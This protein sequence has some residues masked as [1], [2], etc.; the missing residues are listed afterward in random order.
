MSFEDALRFYAAS[1]MR[2][3]GI[4]RGRGHHQDRGGHGGHDHGDPR[5]RRMR[6]FLDDRPPRADRGVVRFLVLD[7]LSE[8]PRH[9]YE[10]MAA[11]ETKSR[12][13]Y[14][15]SPGV[16]YPTLQLLD[17]LG[18]VRVTERDD[19]RVYA[20]TAAGS[21]ELA[22]HADE[23]SRFYEDAEGPWDDRADDLFELAH[24]VKRLLRAFRRSA[25]RGKLTRETMNKATTILDRAIGEL[26][27]LFD[28]RDADEK[29]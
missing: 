23:V 21:R 10:I 27:K 29:A 25:Q 1:R 11:I 19:K 20:I 22:E 26:E 12:G 16:V 13:A 8:T 2:G 17:E 7:A 4:G 3:H 6:E 28:D 9:G 5:W 14:R 18:H 24:M 15:P